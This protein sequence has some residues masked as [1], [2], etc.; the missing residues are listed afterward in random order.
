MSIYYRESFDYP[1]IRMFF[2]SNGADII[3]NNGNVT[4]TL[5]QAIQLLSN[6]LGYISLQELTTLNVVVL[7]RIVNSRN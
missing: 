7:V 5:T 4:F 2:D 6:V 1:P 3:S